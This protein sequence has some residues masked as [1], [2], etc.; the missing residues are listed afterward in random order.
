MRYLDTIVAVA[1][2]SAEERMARAVL[3]FEMGQRQGALEDADWLLEHPPTGMDPDH[4]KDFL[5]RLTEFRIMVE[6]SDR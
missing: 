2:E 3:R 6:R 5:E 1:P 4:Q